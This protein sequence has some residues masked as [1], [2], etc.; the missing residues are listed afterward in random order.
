MT[1]IAYRDGV[2]ASD[3]RAGR[4]N[5]VLPGIEPKLRRMKD[6]SLAGICGD[7]ALGFRLLDWLEGSGPGGRPDTFQTA[8]YWCSVLVVEKSGNATLYEGNGYSVVPGPFYAMGS[9]MAPA[10]GAMHMG[11][12]AERAVEIA[13]QCDPWTGGPIEWMALDGRG[14]QQQP[15]DFRPDSIKHE[16]EKPA[17]VFY[18]A[19]NHREY[20]LTS[21]QVDACVAAFFYSVG[22]MP[23]PDE[24]R[25]E[26]RHRP[27]GIDI[28]RG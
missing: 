3:S 4:G 20:P 21:G 16:L 22:R 7:A 18:D 11:A 6:G 27:E 8:D 13:A 12:N 14:S 2:I 24:R 25:P 19:P 15:A 17:H 1:T 26:Q 23:L 9:G 28:W 10:L 5:F